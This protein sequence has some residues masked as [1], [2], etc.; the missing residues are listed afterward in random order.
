MASVL[1]HFDLNNRAARAGAIF[2]TN[3]HTLP[4]ALKPPSTK[5]PTLKSSTVKRKPSVS[6]KTQVTIQMPLWEQILMYF[7]TFTGVMFSSA[8]M[9]FEAGRIASI[10]ITITTISISFVVAFVIIPI[11]FEKL[12]IKPE[13]PL[14]V[15][16]GLFVQHGVF[17]QVLLGAVGKVFESSS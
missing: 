9:Q 16:I 8:V 11:V 12:R 17:W 5:G 7:A 4:A 15:R 2:P 14:L 6:I 1:N 10:T 13:T 3:I